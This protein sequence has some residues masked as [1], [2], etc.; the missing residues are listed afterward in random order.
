MRKNKSFVIKME[1]FCVFIGIG[2]LVVIAVAGTSLGKGNKGTK[3]HKELA[4]N[5]EAETNKGV[6]SYLEVNNIEESTLEEKRIP[7]TRM[8]V[9]EEIKREI[10]DIH[11]GEYFVVGEE[12]WSKNNF[13]V[14]DLV[15]F[16]YDYSTK[17]VTHIALSKESW[18]KTTLNKNNIN[19]ESQTVTIGEETYKIDE[20]GLIFGTSKERL[21]IEDLGVYDTLQF[22]GIGHQIYSIGVMEEEATLEITDIGAKKGSIQIDKDRQVSL[23]NSNSIIPIKAGKH[24]LIIKIEGYHSVE[25]MLY[26]EPKENRII[27]LKEVQEAYTEVFIR[28]VTDTPNYE[29]QIGDVVYKPEDKIKVRQGR[30]IIKV[31][32]EGFKP[33]VGE[34]LLQEPVVTLNVTLTPLVEEKTSTEEEILTEERAD[35]KI[36]TTIITNP[37]G[38]KVS[39]DGTYSGTTPYTSYLS[40]GEHLID[41]QKQGYE[42]YTTVLVVE[43]TKETKEIYTLSPS[44]NALDGLSG[45]ES[46]GGGSAEDLLGQLLKN[47]LNMGLE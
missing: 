25:Q 18:T 46:L 47:T 17:R 24:N 5:K 36:K 19:K 28:I 29:V 22:Q 23:P 12:D 27:S 44:L 8:G 31:R 38:A 33:W 42:K 10:M 26:I 13:K 30:H 7:V 39:I 15:E 43:G 4:T 20:K 16:I 11:T 3:S 9:V 6:E 34:M 14:G 1:L 37:S 35:T 21:K 45:L 32:A 2:L 40:K 41:L